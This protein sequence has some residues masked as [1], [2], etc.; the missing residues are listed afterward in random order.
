MGCTSSKQ[1]LSDHSGLQGNL[2]KDEKRKADKVYNIDE[3]VMATGT[4]TQIRRG[5]SKIY[6]Y[7]KTGRT[8][9]S[10]AIKL[11]DGKST[12]PLD[13]KEE[14]NILSQCDHP[15][16][17]RLYEVTKTNQKTSL[18]LELCMGGTLQDFVEKQTAPIKE[19]RI[20][21]IMRQIVSAVAY[22]HHNNIVHRDV[23][24]ANI[25]FADDSPESAVKLID[26]GCATKL[27]TPKPGVFKFLTEKTGSI[28]IMAPEI[29]TQGRYGPKC[30]VWSIGVCAYMLCMQGKQPFKGTT[31]KEYENMITKSRMTFGTDWKYSNDAKKFI[32]ECTSTSPASR[33]SAAQALHHVWLENNASN[34]YNASNTSNSTNT[35]TTTTKKFMIPNELSVSLALF[36]RAT[37][38]KR[39]ALN[40]LAMK[41]IGN[42]KYRDLFQRL[43]VGNTG[44]LT[45]TEFI[46]GFTKSGLSPEELED[47]YI[48]LDVNCNDRIMYTEFLAMTMEVDDELI[49]NDNDGKLRE[50]FDILDTD[51]SGYITKKNLLKLLGCSKNN[52]TKQHD[53][54]EIATLKLLE[55]YHDEVSY[56]NFQRLFQR[57]QNVKRNIDAIRESS[58]NEDD[59]EEEENENEEMESNFMMKK[60]NGYVQPPPESS[61]DV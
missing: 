30:D 49:D 53:A 59:E 60:K 57:G 46:N 21:S 14:A 6:E 22:L 26:F 10:V 19:K 48:K 16:I 37:A 42:S 1:Q 28:H 58:D 24:L 33:L 54:H 40:A 31:V 29:I 23:E 35:S 38:L 41:S 5:R 4:S 51:H 56:E 12:L 52:N 55:H 15:N 13:L 7:T 11:Y 27:V 47:A 43:D 50:V 36:Q 45:K 3:D 17:I 34:N 32:L 25:M 8:P 61:P 2:V 39:V 44:Y 9:P 20:I 18:V